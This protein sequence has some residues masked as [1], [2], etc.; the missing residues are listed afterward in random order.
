VIDR[1][2]SYWQFFLIGSTLLSVITVVMGGMLWVIQLLG[3]R[4]AARLARRSSPV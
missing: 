1:S 2:A 4:K 3:S